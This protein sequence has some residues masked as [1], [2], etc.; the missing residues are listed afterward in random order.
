MVHQG[1]HR[2]RLGLK[3][4]SGNVDLQSAAQ[5]L[6]Q[7]GVYD[8]IEL[9]VDPRLEEK[10]LDS[11]QKLRIPYHLHAPHSYSGLNLSDVQAES[12]NRKLISLVSQFYRILN[13]EFVIFH[14][15]IKG[16]IDETIRQIKNF[17]K[18]FPDLFQKALI[19]NKPKIGL[20]GE[21]CLGASAE[22]IRNIM[23]V[24]GLGFCLDIGH[25]ICYSNW[26]KEDW[27]KVLV[28]FLYLSP[29]VFHISDGN[30]QSLADGHEHFGKG[31]YDF[32][33]IFSL[34]PH[35]CFLAIETRHDF[36]DRLDDFF[37]D[38]NYLKT[39]LKDISSL[40]EKIVYLQLQLAGQDDCEAVYI[41]ANDPQV[42]QQS[43]N[44]DFIPWH[45]HQAWFLK[46]FSD[47]NNTR[48]YLAKGSNEAMMGYVR[49]DRKAD[50]AQVSVAVDKN[51]RRKGIGREILKKAIGFIDQD[52]QDITQVSGIVK[53][54]NLASQKLFESLGF[55]KEVSGELISYTKS[56]L[57]NEKLI[58]SN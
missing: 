24:T 49:F 12:S 31:N 56:L 19:E 53:Q 22:E 48:I 15:G 47:L 41:L 30:I 40:S 43:L 39:V 9:Y 36:K 45:V 52:W 57:G 3:L 4:W 2:C 17:K 8:Y 10:G 14:G 46:K 5:D 58:Y 38:A 13:P 54:S 35:D 11:W 55:M 37:Q 26:L 7:K 44:S 27:K 28:E 42:R 51:Y 32:K 16:S 20:N 29:K 1:S 25:A 6:Y 50:V 33:T 18:D 21:I 34:I 23:N